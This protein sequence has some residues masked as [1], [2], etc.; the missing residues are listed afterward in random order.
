MM[1]AGAAAAGVLA[2]VVWLA[3]RMAP[4]RVVTAV[5]GRLFPGQVRPLREEEIRTPGR[6]SG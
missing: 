3:D 1:V 2:G 6:W 5:R 4:R